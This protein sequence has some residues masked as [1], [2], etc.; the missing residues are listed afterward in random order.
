[1]EL[2]ELVLRVSFL[3]WSHFCALLALGESLRSAIVLSYMLNLHAWQFLFIIFYG[4]FLEI[5]LYIISF[6]QLSVIFAL[7]SAEFEFSNDYALSFIA[8]IFIIALIK[9]PEAFCY[10]RLK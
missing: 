6:V 4:Y 10:G 8:E 3:L 5:Q 9:K 2:S 7:W 1:M